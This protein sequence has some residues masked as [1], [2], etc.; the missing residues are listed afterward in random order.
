[1]PSSLERVIP[2][3]LQ[4][5]IRNADRIEARLT[6]PGVVMA[7]DYPGRC[8]VDSEGV[9]YLWRT[10]PLTL[11]PEQAARLRKLLL[12]RTSYQTEAKPCTFSANIHYR[13]FTGPDT[14]EVLICHGCGQVVLWS[15]GVHGGG[16]IDPTALK[17]LGLTRELFPQ[18]TAIAELW[19]RKNKQPPKPY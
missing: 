17:F 5:R 15:R 14:V 12:D 9:G 2:A 16:E 7:S 10:D 11:T 13:V 8:L 6:G 1:L 19:D 4:A 18:D 3:Q